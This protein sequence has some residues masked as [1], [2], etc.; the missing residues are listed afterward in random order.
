MDPEYLNSKESTTSMSNGLGYAI[1]DVF[2]F[3]K[4]ALVK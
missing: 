2:A 4:K 3:F 1:K